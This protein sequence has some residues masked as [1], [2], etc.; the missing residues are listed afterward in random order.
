MAAADRRGAAEVAGQIAEGVREL[1]HL[2]Q[3]L[4]GYPGLEWPSDVS[5]ALGALAAAVGRLPQAAGQLGRF[6]ETQADRPGLY[7][8]RGGRPA[9]AVAAALAALADAAGPLD[10][11]R[12]HLDRAFQVVSRL[13][14]RTPRRGRRR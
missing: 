13:G 3:P 7:D 8:D 5:D 9:D 10:E 14:V 1:N 4:T 6:L 11:A 2:T 12:R